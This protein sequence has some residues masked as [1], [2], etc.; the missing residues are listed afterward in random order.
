ML[1]KHVGMDVLLVDVVIFRNAGTQAGGIQNRTGADD[2]ILRQP[3]DLVR[4]YRSGY[5]PGWLR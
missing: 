3:G 2:V 4:D 5:P 1:A